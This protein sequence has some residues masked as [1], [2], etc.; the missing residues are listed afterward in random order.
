MLSL[1]DLQIISRRA[2]ER[3]DLL[4]SE[5]SIKISLVQPFIRALGY[6][7]QDPS[8][9]AAEFAEDDAPA[10]TNREKVDYAILQDGKAIILVECKALG[11]SLRVAK[12]IKQLAKYYNSSDATVSILTNGVVYKFFSDLA[13]TN[14]MD[15]TPF[16]EV[17]I[18]TADE[19]DVVRL[20]RF[21]K[22]NFDAD[23]IKK[24]AVETNIITGAKANLQKMYAAPDDEFSRVI[25]RNVG[26]SNLAAEFAANHR[27]LARQ[28]FHEFVRE[29]GNAEISGVFP[30]TTAGASQIALGQAAVAVI[31]SSALPDAP[32][33]GWYAL[34]DVQPNDNDFN[35]KQLMFPGNAVEDITAWSEVVVKVILWLTKNGHLD[36]QRCTIQRDLSRHLVSPRPIHPDGSEFNRA[37]KVRS[38]YVELQDSAPALI[39]DAKLII[40]QAGM[41]AS[42]FKLRW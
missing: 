38:L 24:S 30:Q 34:S 9:V 39:N 28:A 8:E 25:L 14:I 32:T 36:A 29:Q 10:T 23:K 15:Q 1:K 22:D 27:E 31:P 35:P 13:K 41:D 2:E 42:Q 12:D 5:E 26:A 33:A 17:D 20:R 6:D 40:S 19:G 4:T 21:A 16:W 3:R 7:F 37:Q 18:R 11:N